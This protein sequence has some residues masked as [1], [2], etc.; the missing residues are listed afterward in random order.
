MIRG[1]PQTVFRFIETPELAKRW[2]PDVAE[3]EIT[4]ATVG[5]VGT[6]FR[7]VLRSA[8]G[9]IEMRGRITAYA[10]NALMEFDVAGTG[11]RVRTRYGVNPAPQGTRLDVDADIHVGGRLSWLIERLVRRRMVRQFDAELARLRNLA[12]AT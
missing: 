7:E 5:V 3:Y 1:E 11:I 2:Q 9:S 6:E 4:R 12:E 8:T 10:K